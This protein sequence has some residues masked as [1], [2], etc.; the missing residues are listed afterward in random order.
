MYVMPDG[1][2]D[3]LDLDTLMHMEAEYGIFVSDSGAEQDKLMQARQ[4]SQAMIQNGVPASTVL[5]MMEAGSFTQLKDKIAKA[6]KTV[7]EL[8]AQQQQAQQQ[9]QEQALAAKAEEQAKEFENDDKDRQNKMTIAE[10]Q[11]DTQIKIAELKADVDLQELDALRQANDNKHVVEKEKISEQRRT[12]QAKEATD[13]SKAEN[14]KAKV[15]VQ[16]AANKDKR[17][18]DK[19]KIEVEKTKAKSQNSKPK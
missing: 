6:E 9:M 5:D 15:D 2:T 17:A 1:T 3:F 8:E 13:R 10:L 19:A 14:D 18:T 12:S 11:A 7:Q 16:R 4:L